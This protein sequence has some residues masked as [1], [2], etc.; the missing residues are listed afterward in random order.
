M[1]GNAACQRMLARC[2]RGFLGAMQPPTG[3]ELPG[4]YGVIFH[5]RASWI[6]DRQRHHVSHSASVATSLSLESLGM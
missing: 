3:P 4:G 2:W 5:A 6:P 1:A